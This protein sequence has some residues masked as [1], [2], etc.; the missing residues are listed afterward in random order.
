MITLSGCPCRPWLASPGSAPLYGQESRDARGRVRVWLGKG[1]ELA[2]VGGW[3]WRYRLVARFAL[4]RG[5][6]Q[7]E[8][9]DH[10]NGIVDDDRAENLRVMA[11]EMH[12]RYHAL[13]FTVAG[14]RGSD[15]RFVELEEPVREVVNRMGPVLSARAIDRCS[16][17][18]VSQTITAQAT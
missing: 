14:C 6:Y 5:L 3:Q 4:G 11:A 2:N 17:L 1:H 15:G 9:V 7:G 13:L 10:V 8:H 12:G 16:W 18:P